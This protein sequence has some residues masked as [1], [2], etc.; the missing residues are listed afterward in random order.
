MTRVRRV[1]RVRLWTTTTCAVFPEMVDPDLEIELETITAM[2]AGMLLG[3]PELR[4]G[5]RC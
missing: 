1:G 2:K 5:R 3:G 4:S